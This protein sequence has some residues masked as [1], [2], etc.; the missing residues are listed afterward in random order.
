MAAFVRDASAHSEAGG[1]G[2]PKK[3]S[4]AMREMLGPQ[5]VDQQI[6]QAISFCWQMLPEDKKNPEAVAAEIRRVVERALANLKED[7]ES[8]G[9]GTAT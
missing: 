1:E 2:D 4:A 7:A 9:F 8:F 3:M 6:R 5:A